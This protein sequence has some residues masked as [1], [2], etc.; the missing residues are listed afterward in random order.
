MFIDKKKASL[1]ISVVILGCLVMGIVDAIIQPGYVIKSMIKIIF[2]LILP[3]ILAIQDRNLSLRTLFNF[4]RK[5]I[6]RALLLGLAIY[7]L[8]IGAYFIIRNFYDFSSITKILTHDVGVDKN[9]FVWVALY[10]SFVN[11][12][13]EEFFFRGFAFLKLQQFISRKYAYI[14]SSFMFAIYH[15]AIMKGWF[16]II[17]FVLAILALMIGGCIFNYLDERN[18]NIYNSWM[19][20]AFA[21]FAIN[22]VGFILFGIL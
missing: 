15:V 17:L 22:T 19:V 3:M 20:H 5:G 21:N 6:V 4:E 8:I 9:N 18:R 16:S 12:L 11:S 14:I 10:I 7:I 2:F 1:I 13:L